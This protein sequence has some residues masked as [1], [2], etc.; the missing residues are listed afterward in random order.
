MTPIKIQ[1][2][3]NTPA[4]LLDPSKG[5]F[6]LFGRSSPENSIQFYEPIRTAL[7][8]IVNVSKVD[9]RIKMEYFN[10]SSS[11]CI[12]D[13]LKEVKSLKDRGLNVSVRW[14]F[15]EDDEDMQEAGEDYS[16]LLDLPFIMIEYLPEGGAYKRSA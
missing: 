7:A 9:V 1:P 11:K 16:D 14:Y 13:L 6:K 4:V 10:T 5:V 12:Y 3:R 15:D 2:T 8:S